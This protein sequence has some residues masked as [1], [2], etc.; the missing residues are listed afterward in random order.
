MIDIFAL[1]LTHG[2]MLLAVVR[3]L[4][5]DELDREELAEQDLPGA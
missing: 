4:Q 3:L 2:L 5:R 1:V